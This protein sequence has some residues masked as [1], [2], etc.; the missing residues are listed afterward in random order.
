MLSDMCEYMSLL[1]V[2]LVVNVTKGSNI[3]Y[4]HFF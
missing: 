3:F 2:I 4:I 1:L